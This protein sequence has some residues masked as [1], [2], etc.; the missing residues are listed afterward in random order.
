MTVAD[1]SIDPK[2]LKYAKKEFL[3]HGFQKT[4]LK[5][6]CR[7]AGVTTGALYKRYK[8]KEDLFCALVQPAIQDIELIAQ[9]K[10]GCDPSTFSDEELLLAW[11]M[12]D[13][14]SFSKSLQG[15]FD[16]L[17]ARKEEFTLLL[18]CAEGTCYQNFISTWVDRMTDSTYLYLEE[19]KRRKISTRNIDEDELRVLMTCFWS[20]IYKPFLLHFNQKQLQLH[21][22]IV[23]DMFDWGMILGIHLPE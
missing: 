12:N 5:D 15:W 18:T 14:T 2:I 11:G 10:E 21:C 6:I 8:G 9:A 13:R 1:T 16:F 7:Q 20:S 17:Y 19:I 23:C 4:Q 3:K 22:Q